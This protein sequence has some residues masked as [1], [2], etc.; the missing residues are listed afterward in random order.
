MGFAMDDGGDF[1]P[2]QVAFVVVIDGATP[3]GPAVRAVAKTS[4]GGGGVEE[5]TTGAAGAAGA[6]HGCGVGEE[7]VILRGRDEAAARGEKRADKIGE[8]FISPEQFILHRVLEVG[9]GNVGGAAEFSV[10]GMGKLVRQE[11]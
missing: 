8:T 9:C 5:R 11:Q 3:V 10:P 6:E 4:N 7:F 1:E 2:H